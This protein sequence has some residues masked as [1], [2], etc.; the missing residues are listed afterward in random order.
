M[1]VN[2]WSDA[3]PTP[4]L[5]RTVKLK[6]EPVSFVGVP[7]MAPVEELSEAHG[8]NVPLTTL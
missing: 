3:E 7:V 4:L 2:A 1:R 8:G 6:G 5:A